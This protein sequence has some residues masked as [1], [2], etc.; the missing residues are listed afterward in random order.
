VQSSTRRNLKHDRFAE[1]V[2]QGT[3]ENRSALIRIAIMVGVVLAL[4][5]GGWLYVDSRNDAANTEL[6]VAMHTYQAPLRAPGTTAT[7]EVES[8][9]SAK[10]RAVAAHKKF[11]QIANDFSLT[12]TGKMALYL[13]GVTD[14]DAGD[15]AAGEQVLKT[16]ASSWNKDVSSLSH[17]AL[18]SYYRDNKKDTDAIDQYQAI[19]KADAS[20]V[21]RAVAQL[22]LASLYEV[23]KK[24]AEAIKIYEEIQKDGSTQPEA[25][26][27]DPKAL[28]PGEKAPPAPEPV[29][30]AAAES[31]KA[32]IDQ[33]KKAAGADKKDAEPPKK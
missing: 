13:S 4:I 32:K 1:A 5:F 28:K 29:L 14:I 11:A 9:T 30:S 8:Y 26:K 15:A 23:E 18:A 22:D 7:P 31:A 10:E 24:P 2:V 16:A 27:A 33:L 20:S 25:M 21:P 19:I 12:R 17:Y 3:V 6:G